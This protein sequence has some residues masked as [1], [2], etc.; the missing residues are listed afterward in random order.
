MPVVVRVNADDIIWH[1]PDLAAIL[2][3]RPD[4]IMLPKCNSPRTL[5][6]LSDRLDALEAAFGLPQ[7]SVAVLPL[8]TETA[9]ALA[10][11]AYGN[12]TPRLAALCFVAEDWEPISGS[13]PVTG[14]R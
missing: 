12:V 14:R 4:A 8:I 7:C 9:G 2:P 6:R 1:L 10:D 11:M 3:G 5:R 13:M